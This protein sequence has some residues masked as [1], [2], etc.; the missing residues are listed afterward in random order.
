MGGSPRST[1]LFRKVDHTD[2]APAHWMVNDP[3]P[4]QTCSQFCNNSNW[5]K[6][7]LDYPMRHFEHKHFN[8]PDI[9]QPNPSICEN[10]NI[11]D[12]IYPAYNNFY[13]PSSMSKLYPA[14][15]NTS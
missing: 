7:P 12:E 3:L 9:P 5:F 1:S 15:D 6:R 8:A 14:S 2:H 4:K 10:C 13:L 11:L